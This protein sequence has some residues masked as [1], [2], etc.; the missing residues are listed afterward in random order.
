M[1]VGL[2]LLLLALALPGHGRANV[3][4][5]TVVG[6]VRLERPSAQSPAP[7]FA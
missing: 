4:F 6:E 2:P 1:R 5:V 3:E 7:A